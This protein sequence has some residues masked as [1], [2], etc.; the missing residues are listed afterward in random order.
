MLIGAQNPFYKISKPIQKNV[1]LLI[2]VLLIEH[3]NLV[4]YYVQNDLQYTYKDPSTRELGNLNPN[5][6]K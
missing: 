6:S 3:P 5:V 2:H 1:V 4:I